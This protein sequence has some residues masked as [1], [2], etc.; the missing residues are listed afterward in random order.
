[1]KPL[2]LA[3]A[4][5]RRAQL[6]RE[7]GWDFDCAPVHLSEQQKGD[8]S[9]MAMASRL[10]EQKACAALRKHPEA[11]V[12]G[13][14]TLAT[15]KGQIFGKP[16]GHDDFVSMM[17]CLSD[18]THEVV[19]GV[20]VMSADNREVFHCTTEVTFIPLSADWIEDYWAS[21][22]PCDKAGGYALQGRAGEKVC[23]LQGS[24][25][26]VIGLPMEETQRVLVQFGVFP[27][28]WVRA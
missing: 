6:L 23:G 19:S 7:A 8:E 2:I 18:E 25:S 28:P 14:D 22:E 11:V 26:N 3:S 27:A 4:S 1:M 16:T 24:H 21:G 20:C 15:Q 9:A 10:A 5:S 12:L 13:A 17:N